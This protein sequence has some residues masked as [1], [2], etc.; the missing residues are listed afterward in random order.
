MGEAKR[1]KLLDP[2]YGKAGYSDQRKKALANFPH[3][4]LD[5]P[6]LPTAASEYEAYVHAIVA[7]QRTALLACAIESRKEYTEAMCLAVLPSPIATESPAIT[8]C[9]MEDARVL[10]RRALW[11]LDQS[12]V[13]NV[14]ELF[15]IALS[16]LKPRQ[17]LWTHLDMARKGVWTRLIP[18]DDSDIAQVCGCDGSC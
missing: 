3:I 15:D 8:F 4:L 13:I 6:S 16:E 7:E 5:T 18:I 14:D 12:D 1:R 2:N 10:W 11:R 9:E 17:F